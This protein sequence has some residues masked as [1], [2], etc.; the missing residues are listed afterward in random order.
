ML[1]KSDKLFKGWVFF[2]AL[3]RDKHFRGSEKNLQQL[4]P[5]Q[6][7]HR[8]PRATTTGKAGK[9]ATTEGT[10]RATPNPTAA[11]GTRARNWRQISFNRRHEKGYAQTRATQARR[12]RKFWTL[13]REF[14]REKCRFQ[15]A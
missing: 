7:S 10:K 12:A 4:H 1:I 14:E 11:S 2:L 9:I 3:K 6:D 13:R 15:G 8:P 5:N